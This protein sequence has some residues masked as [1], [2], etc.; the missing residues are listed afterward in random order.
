M[1]TRRDLLRGAVAGAVLLPLRAAP[2][3]SAAAGDDPALAC[4]IQTSGDG[5]MTPQTVADLPEP[6]TQAFRV[7]RVLTPRTD[8]D[9]DHY[10]IEMRAADA[11][12][13]PGYTTPIWGYDGTLP[14]PTIVATRGRATHVRQANGLDVPVTVHLHGGHV[15]PDMDGHATRG[16]I[17]PGGQFTYR[18]PNTQLGATLWYHDHA[19]H[20][21]GR[22]VH[23]GLFGLYVVRDPAE[24]ALGLPAG[25]RDLPL[26]LADRSFDGDG[27]MAYPEGVHNGFLGDVPLVNGV[28]QPRADVDGA[29]YRLRI[30]NASNARRYDVW[31]EAESGTPLPFTQI[32]S[33]GGLLAAPVVRERIQ[34][35]P[36][37][38]VDVVVDFSA[39]EPGDRVVLANAG[40]GRIRHLMRFDV[41]ARAADGSKVPAALAAIA[42][43]AGAGAQRDVALSQEDGVWKIQGHGFDEDI[44]DFS[45]RLGATEVWTL[46]NP[47]TLPHPMH[48]HLVQFQVLDRDGK[49]PEPWER[50][51][52]DT[53]FV[54]AAETVRV[55][56]RFD[57]WP[58]VYIYHCHNL[59]HE[60]HDMMSQFRVL[61]V[62]RVAGPNR[63]ATAAAVSRRAFPDGAAVALVAT[64]GAFPDALA[65]GLGGQ[66]VRA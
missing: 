48:L 13:L 36:A 35:S 20:S 56:A 23:N 14:G 52:K 27:R 39:L 7:P 43:L 49:P 29:R 21:T 38:R 33:D 3:T 2:A 5:M 10:D 60:D 51:W 26:L 1:L 24:D 57:G 40:T 65:G 18:Y 37:E 61:D 50:G 6:F 66:R 31:L 55:I 63:V 42:P 64:A 9:G 8:A 11:E 22:N 47:T 19:M 54:N 34:L 16:L 58:G 44:V 15:P 12:I 45:P 41:G 25:E 62:P 59:E 17:A 53:V 32:A 30:L 46:R 28:V 4:R